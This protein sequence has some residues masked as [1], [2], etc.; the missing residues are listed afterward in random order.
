MLRVD[1]GVVTGKALFDQVC[2]RDLEGVVGKP[3]D[4]PYATVLG[5]PP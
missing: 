1:V 2:R 5:K 4:S 3:L